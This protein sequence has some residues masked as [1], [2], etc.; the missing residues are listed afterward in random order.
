VV[1]KPINLYEL[2]PYSGTTTNTDA[3]AATPAGNARATARYVACSAY[4]RYG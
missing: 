4:T 1:I 3:F 2:L